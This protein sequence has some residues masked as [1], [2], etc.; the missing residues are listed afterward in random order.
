MKELEPKSTLSIAHQQEA[1]KQYG[2]LRSLIPKPGHSVFE[3]NM[4]TGSLVKLEL[5]K[6][7]VLN[8]DRT[9]STHS[10]AYEK[11]GCLYI[12]AL[13]ERNAWKRLRQIRDEMKRQDPDSFKRVNPEQEGG[14]E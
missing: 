13:N 5:K 6:E 4:E 9:L 2:L 3:F 7:L 14:G 10:K 1:P 11:Q 8:P 12:T